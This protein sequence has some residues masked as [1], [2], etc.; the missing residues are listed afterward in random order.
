MFYISWL[1]LADSLPIRIRAHLL[2]SVGACTPTEYILSKTIKP[3]NNGRARTSCFGFGYAVE[4]LKKAKA[5][6]Y[7]WLRENA[8]EI[9][10]E[11]SQ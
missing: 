11:D 3:E 9:M 1:H 8:E 4:Y 6:P 7:K 2:T 10:N 5:M